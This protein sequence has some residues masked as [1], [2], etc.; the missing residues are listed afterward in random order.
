MGNGII[1]LYRKKKPFALRILGNVGAGDLV[2]QSDPASGSSIAC[3][4]LLSCI[5]YHT[6]ELMPIASNSSKRIALVVER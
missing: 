5:S 4:A 2:F 3:L 6:L 1:G